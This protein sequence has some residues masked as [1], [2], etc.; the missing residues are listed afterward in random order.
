MRWST[1]G[2]DGASNTHYF[3]PA[4]LGSVNCF[5]MRV[6][7]VVTL[8]NSAR[9][10]SAFAQTIPLVLPL[11]GFPCPDIGTHWRLLTQPARLLFATTHRALRRRLTLR[12]IPRAEATRSAAGR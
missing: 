12:A 5:A 2:E 4:C 11:V 8:V 1:S 10:R 6:P 7:T 9:H 3:S